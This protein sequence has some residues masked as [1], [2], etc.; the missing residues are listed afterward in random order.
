MLTNGA[1][2]VGGRKRVD[3]ELTG[4]DVP[5]L[6]ADFFNDAAVFVTHRG[7]MRDRL[8]SPI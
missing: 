2:V 1:S 5:D 3:H 7:W 8:N 4:L 6:L